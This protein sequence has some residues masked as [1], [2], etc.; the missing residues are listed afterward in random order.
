MLIIKTKAEKN[1][2]DNTQKIVNLKSNG[3]L[4]WKIVPP[5]VGIKPPKSPDT[6]ELKHTKNNAD[7]TAITF[8]LKTKNNVNVEKP[9]MKHAQLKYINF[10]NAT[11][12]VENSRKWI[13]IT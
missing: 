4:A 2:T 5:F 9:T 1:I 8:K 13:F 7:E 12:F 11:T 6:S 3:L 10:F